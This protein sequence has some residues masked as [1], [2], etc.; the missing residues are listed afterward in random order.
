MTTEQLQ[1]IAAHYFIWDAMGG[2]GRSRF[3]RTFGA[4]LAPDS[5]I[6]WWLTCLLFLDD[7]GDYNRNYTWAELWP[8]IE[9]LA[10]ASGEWPTPSE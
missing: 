6:G 2:Y 10:V 4:T 5:P 3:R 1:R 8:V 7:D 9:D